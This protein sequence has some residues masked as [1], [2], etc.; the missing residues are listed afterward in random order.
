MGNESFNEVSSGT[1]FLISYFTFLMIVTIVMTF[2]IAFVMTFVMVVMLFVMTFVMP[3]VMT[4]VMIVMR[5]IQ[6]DSVVCDKGVG[7]RLC[8]LYIKQFI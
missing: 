5:T 1:Q 4:F 2:M 6:E 7:P 3:F 8:S